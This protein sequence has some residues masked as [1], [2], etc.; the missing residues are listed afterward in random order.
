M[1]GNDVLLSENILKHFEP[2]INLTDG[3]VFDEIEKQLINQ[4]YKNM[5]LK[6]NNKENNIG[7]VKVHI[8]EPIVFGDKNIDTNSLLPVWKKE[9][10]EIVDKVS[11]DDNISLENIKYLGGM[12]ISF[13]KD[14][15]RGVACLVVF[16]FKTMEIVA[17]FS[18]NYIV[19]IP[20]IVG[21]LAFR[22]VP[23]LLKLIEIINRDYP[24]L[25]PQLILMDG[26]G[27]W[28]PRSCGIATHFSILTGIP[29]IGVAKNVLAV[30]NITDDVVHSLLKENAP[31][32]NMSIKIVTTSGRVLGCAYNATG[33]I[34][35]SLYVSIG[36]GISLD[37]AMRVVEL[38]N[39]YRVSETIRQADHISRL[40]L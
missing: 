2:E 6:N 27:V 9:Q 22:E 23:P 21:Y 36:N 26:N 3:I 40:L 12:D 31:E 34:K 16:D 13:E 18:I 24:E 38:V 10:K 25:L 29:C 32:K 11:S 5:L 30:E 35:K 14:S 39:K 20:Y 33:T 17:Q 28:H 1:N 7:I 8:T 19:D 4:K 37:T 15:N